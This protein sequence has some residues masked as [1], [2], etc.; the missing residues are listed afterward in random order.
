MTDERRLRSTEA[1][2]R[3]DL[4]IIEL[5]CLTDQKF[6]TMMMMWALLLCL[7]EAYDDQT[8]TR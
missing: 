6:Y 1:E 4:T 3:L 5:R 8:L 7:G 2:Q